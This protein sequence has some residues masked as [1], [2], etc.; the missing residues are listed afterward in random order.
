MGTEKETE[1]GTE[2]GDEK[3]IGKR[4]RE[5]NRRSTKE[6][7]GTESWVDKPTILPYSVQLLPVAG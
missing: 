4:T 5:R 6:L 7:D 2:K 1:K 3:E